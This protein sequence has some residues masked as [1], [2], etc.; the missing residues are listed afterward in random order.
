MAYAHRAACGRSNFQ[1]AITENALYPRVGVAVL[2]PKLKWVFRGFY[3]RFYQPPPLTSLSGPALEYA[4]G[5]NTSFVALKGERDEEHQFGVQIPWRGWLLDADT[6][7]TR[8]NNFLDHSNIGES[9]IFVPV[10]VQGALIQAWELTLR[11]PSSVALRA[12][13]SGVFQSDCAA[14]R[15]DHRRPDLLSARFPVMRGCA[16]IFG[17]GPRPAK[18]PERRHE[19]QPSLSRLRH[20]S[21]STMAR[22]SP[23]AI[24]THRLLITGAYLPGTYYGGYGCR[25]GN[26][27]KLLGLRRIAEHCQHARACSTTVSPSEA[28]TI[29]IRAKSTGRCATAS[30]SD[31]R[32]VAQ[33]KLPIRANTT[34]SRP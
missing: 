29:T 25:Q 34:R 21:I 27:R 20:R 2:I 9:S 8:A 6:F 30:T 24:R 32:V 7:Q 33:K 1:G 14:D 5:T 3:G 16:R 11:S 19:R 23:T 31:G 22:D 18:H 10:T 13:S 17:T 4:N 28:S 15:A 26:W 12:V